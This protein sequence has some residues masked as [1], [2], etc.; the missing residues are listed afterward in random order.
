MVLFE[1]SPHVL[2][3]SLKQSM[4]EIYR[5]QFSTSV[6]DVSASAAAG[7][8]GAATGGGGSRSSSGGNQAR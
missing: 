3:K 7:T 1:E 4:D 5:Y 8:G 6:S 2:H